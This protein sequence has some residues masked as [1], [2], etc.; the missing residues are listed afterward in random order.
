M[1]WSHVNQLPGFRVDPP[2]QGRA[3]MERQ[4]HAD[5]LGSERR[6]LGRDRVMQSIWAANP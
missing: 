3:G 2:P 4:G 1:G 6:A 5:R